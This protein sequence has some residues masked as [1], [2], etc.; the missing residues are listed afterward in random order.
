MSIASNVRARIGCGVLLLVALGLA[1]C[2]EHPIATR[3]LEQGTQGVITLPAVEGRACRYGGEYP[4]C[5]SGPDPDGGADPGTEPPPATGGDDPVPS[6]STFSEGDCPAVDPTCKTPLGEDDKQSLASALQMIN[7]NA[8]P[9]CAQLADKLAELGT[10]RV[11]RGAYNSGHSGEAGAGDI[12]ID[13]RFWIAANSNGGSSIAV[14]AEALLH[15]AAHLL[16]W[17][18]PGESSTP[19]RTF[20]FDHMF[21]SNSGVPQCVP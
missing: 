10:T 12:H 15:E 20:P 18:H 8:A 17:D 11:F 9:V 21:N 13:L 19:Y 5:Q 16:G 4:F 6:G 7:R 1:G 2:A 3:A 14:L